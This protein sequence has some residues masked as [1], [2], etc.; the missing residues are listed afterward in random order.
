M[1]IRV[2][3]LQK[4]R[5]TLMAGFLNSHDTELVKDSSGKWFTTGNMSEG[6]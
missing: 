3:V 4:V 2:C 1:P 6:A 5:T